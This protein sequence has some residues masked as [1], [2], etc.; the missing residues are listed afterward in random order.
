MVVTASF[1]DQAG[2]KWFTRARQSVLDWVSVSIQNFALSLG[3][4]EAIH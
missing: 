2:I 4:K 1:V 3:Q